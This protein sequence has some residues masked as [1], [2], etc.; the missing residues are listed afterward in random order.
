MDIVT[1]ATAAVTEHGQSSSLSSSSDSLFSSLAPDTTTTTNETRPQ[2]E[3]AKHSP[4]SQ[5]TGAL[6][7]P[8]GFMPMLSFSGPSHGIEWSP[9]SRVNGILQTPVSTGSGLLADD[10]AQPATTTYIDPELA[11]KTPEEWLELYKQSFDDLPV[12]ALAQAQHAFHARIAIERAFSRKESTMVYFRPRYQDTVDST[13]MIRFQ[14]RYAN[15]TYALATRVNCTDKVDAMYDSIIEQGR[16]HDLVTRDNDMKHEIREC[17]TVAACDKVLKNIHLLKDHYKNNLPAEAEADKCATEWLE[18]CIAKRTEIAAA[19]TVGDDDDVDGKDEEP[20]EDEPV[21]G[22]RPCHV[23]GQ[24]SYS[25]GADGKLPLALHRPIPVIDTRFAPSRI[26]KPGTTTPSGEVRFD[27]ITEHRIVGQLYGVNTLAVSGTNSMWRKLNT[28]VYIPCA[29]DG[30]E[31]EVV[32]VDHERVMIVAMPSGKPTGECYW[33]VDPPFG[34]VKK[35]IPPQQKSDFKMTRCSL[36]TRY[37]LVNGY[38][39]GS[40]IQSAFV[41][42]RDGGWITMFDT[43][44]P[45]SYAILSTTM[46]DTILF[47]FVEGTLIR[48]PIPTQKSLRYGKQ[49]VCVYPPL[50]PVMVARLTP[51]SDSLPEKLNE[52]MKTAL[53]LQRKACGAMASVENAAVKYN[54]SPE[55]YGDWVMHVGEPNAVTRILERGRRIIAATS[56]GLHLFTTFGLIPYD[57]VEDEGGRRVTMNI[58]NNASYDFRGNLLIVHKT[59]H[60]IQIMQL[61]T[62]KM[63]VALDPPTVLV[64]QPPDMDT[65]HSTIAMHDRTIIVLHSDGTRRVIELDPLFVTPGPGPETATTEKNAA[66]KKSTEKKARAKK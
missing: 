28:L 30:L 11:P 33:I 8:G 21:K 6:P 39:R 61:H 60:A 56:H 40:D 59:N 5:T 49:R 42:H 18:F 62:Y 63:E 43:S 15:N 13:T 58:R 54:D 4:L 37:I 14:F 17:K 64:P 23:I 3:E 31:K 57:V 7:K 46:E 44:V 32:I 55:T 26:C 34:R 66:K 53:R 36:S 35:N 51:L 29:M 20:V 12:P 24:V 48:H 27:W 65:E 45:M 22:E 10:L 2:E 9:I 25:I 41:I 1:E 50:H 16:A 38:R 52:A 47:G 19:V